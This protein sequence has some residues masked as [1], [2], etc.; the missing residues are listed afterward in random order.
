MN[1]IHV[2]LDS[3]FRVTTGV[4]PRLNRLLHSVVNSSQY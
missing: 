2:K 4:C 1:L 3:G